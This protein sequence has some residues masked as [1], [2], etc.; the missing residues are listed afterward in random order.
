MLEPTAAANIIYFRFN[1]DVQDTLNLEAPA[2]RLATFSRCTREVHSSLLVHNHT[3]L[4]KK[5]L[6]ARY[7]VRTAQITFYNFCA[8][9]Q[10]A[11]MD[12]KLL[13]LSLW[14]SERRSSG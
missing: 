13:H 5:F 10:D 4:L 9:A 2:A 3:L 14:R 11:N 8:R 1:I 12:A 6:P 7:T